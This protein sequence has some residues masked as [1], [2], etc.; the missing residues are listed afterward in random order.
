MAKKKFYGS[1]AR[2]IL[3][4]CFVL[5]VV[6]LIFYSTIIWDRDWRIKLDTIFSELRLIGD[7]SLEIYK[8]WHERRSL[9]LENFTSSASDESLSMMFIFDE[10]FKV[11][12]SSEK[13]MEGGASFFPDQLKQALREGELVFAAFNPLT[14]REEIFL[15]KQFDREIRGLSVTA[16]SWIEQFVHEREF[17]LSL[18]DQ[19]DKFILSTA[20]HLDHSQ[21]VV[22]TQEQIEKWLQGLSFSE[23]YSLRNR[24]LALRLNL[25]GALFDLQ[26]EITRDQIKQLEGGMVF[27]RL[28]EFM[29]LFIILG[30]IGAFWLIRRMAR[31]FNQLS[32]VMDAVEIKDYERRY[33]EDRFGFEINELGLKFNEMLGILLSNMEEAKNQRVK[34][35]ILLKELQIGRDVQ[36]ELLPKEIP[37][38]PGLQFGLGFVPAKE[39]GGDFYDLFVIDKDQLMLAIADASD[40]GISACLYSLIVRSLLRSYTQSEQKLAE[41]LLQTNNLFYHDAQSTSNFV[42]AWVGFY[43]VQNQILAYSSAGHLPALLLHPNGEIEELT[44]A[45]IALGVTS[46]KEIEVRTV[47]LAPGSLLFLYTDGLI[48]THNEKGELFGKSRLFDFLKTHRTLEPQKL[49]E[50]LISEVELFAK[51]IAQH[52]DLTVLCLKNS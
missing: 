39:V 25:P 45:G 47:R 24:H 1:L 49:I 14:N 34:K 26:I 13:E 33:K 2:R 38:F 42:T 44:T 9:Q 50:G 15:L 4:I 29:I 7:S 5:I 20:L 46:L 36:N 8:Q 11:Q 51:Q 19:S 3:V 10:N 31:P 27:R 23:A 48:E 32:H 37:Q 18:V 16:V 12:F 52:D 35:E 40:K 21:E 22:F 17:D 43:N 6:P 41:T 28:V 30:G